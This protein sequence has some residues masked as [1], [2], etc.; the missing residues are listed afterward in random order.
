MWRA[1]QKVYDGNG[2]LQVIPISEFMDIKSCFVNY[3]NL[4]VLV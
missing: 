2:I 4:F 1:S 3:P